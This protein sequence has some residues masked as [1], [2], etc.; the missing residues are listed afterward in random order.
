MSR[1]RYA[2]GK[3]TAFGFEIWSTFSRS[4]DDGRAFVFALP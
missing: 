1:S 2:F 3:P 4:V